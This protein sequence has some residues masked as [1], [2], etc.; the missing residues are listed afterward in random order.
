MK[1]NHLFNLAAFCLTSFSAGRELNSASLASNSTLNRHTFSDTLISA[2]PSGIYESYMRK[3]VPFEQVVVIGG[4]PIGLTASLLIAGN[5]PDLRVTIIEKRGNPT[6]EGLTTLYSHDTKKF[7]DD[8]M[9]SYGKETDPRKFM[10]RIKDLEIDLK[11]IFMNLV[12]EQPKKY[13]LR[14]NCEL[15]EILNGAIITSCEII[16]TKGMPTLVVGADGSSSRVRGLM[17]IEVEN[18][19]SPIHYSNLVLEYDNDKFDLQEQLR[20]N[21]ILSGLR[22]FKNNSHDHAQS[23][24]NEGELNADDMELLDSIPKEYLNWLRM[25]PI[26][27][28]PAAIQIFIAAPDAAAMKARRKYVDQ[29]FLNRILDPKK[30]QIIEENKGVFNVSKART[31]TASCG[32]ECEVVLVGD[33]RRTT[34]PYTG[35]GLL[36]GLD[37]LREEFLPLLESVT[38]PKVTKKSASQAFSHYN[39]QT[40]IRIKEDFNNP[41]MVKHSVPGFGDPPVKEVP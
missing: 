38:D 6:R 30:N 24:F 39:N 23:L 35:A 12:K 25:I 31:T 3:V 13:S 18:L 2:T 14:E 4:G 5:N 7:L 17:G 28:N 27:G 33:S 15:T 32:K 1:V 8:L 11:D 10:Y 16:G 40:S 29:A 26:P 37:G 36:G 22:Q 21:S 34:H 9:K 20:V 19:S 41:E